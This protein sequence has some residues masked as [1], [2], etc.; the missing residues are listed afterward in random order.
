MC[1]C[2]CVLSN[3]VAGVYHVVSP[4]KSRFAPGCGV[5]FPELC[6]CKFDEATFAGASLVR[7]REQ[8]NYYLQCFNV[9]VHVSLCVCVC[10]CMAIFSVCVHIVVGCLRMQMHVLPLHIVHTALQ[11]RSGF[12]SFDSSMHTACFMC[13]I[14]SPCVA[15]HCSVWI[16]RDVRSL[17]YRCELGPHSQ[18]RGSAASGCAHSHPKL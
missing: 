11:A 2:L 10:V 7:P 14:F 13:D 17:V 6:T 9:C 4:I 1:V 18:L 3:S 16:D 15:F 5:Q 8:L 12:Y